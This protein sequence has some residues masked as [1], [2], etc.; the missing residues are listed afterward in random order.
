MKKILKAAIEV[1]VLEYRRVYKNVSLWSLIE[2]KS[3][4]KTDWLIVFFSRFITAKEIS[5]GARKFKKALPKMI[6][7]QV[8]HLK[9]FLRSR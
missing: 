3:I 2:K 5:Y 9:S 6:T 4:S 8:T 7:V 1:S